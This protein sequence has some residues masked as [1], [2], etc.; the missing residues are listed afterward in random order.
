[1]IFE[2]FEIEIF[3]IFKNAAVQFMPAHPPKHG[4]LY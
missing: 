3:K 1:M 2:N 4:L